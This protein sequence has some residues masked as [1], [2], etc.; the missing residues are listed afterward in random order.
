MKRLSSIITLLRRMK[1]ETKMTRKMMNV[2]TTLEKEVLIR[3][4]RV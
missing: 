1:E 3:G 4:T 2:R